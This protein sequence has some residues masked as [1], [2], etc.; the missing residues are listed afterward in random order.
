MVGVIAATNRRIEI[1][2]YCFL[3][4][5]VVIADSAYARPWR[6]EESDGAPDRPVSVSLGN[7]VWV[8][9]GAAARVVSSWV[10]LH[11]ANRAS[12]AGA[13]ER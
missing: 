9:A 2:D 7:D 12:T 1:G 5:E 6:D 13:T 10:W 3:A 8:G 4:H 11:P